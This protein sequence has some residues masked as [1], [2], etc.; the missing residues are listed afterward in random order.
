MEGDLGQGADV[1][2]IRGQAVGARLAVVY[3]GDSVVALLARSG[4]A[5]A[6]VLV[7]GSASLP[8]AV[9]VA[10]DGQLTVGAAALAASGQCPDGLVINPSL[11]LTADRVKVGEV[12]VDPVDLIAATLRAVGTA[13]DQAVVGIEITST[14]IAVPSRWGTRRRTA[15]RRAARRAG[16]SDPQI[17]DAPA[18]IVTH[19]AAA[20][21]GGSVVVCRHDG[22]HLE[23]TVLRR[24]ESGFETL[25]TSDPTVDTADPGAGP[26][27]G[28]VVAAI[29][30]TLAAADIAEGQLTAVLLDVPVAELAAVTAGLAAHLT[31]RAPV[32]VAGYAA[33]YGAL[34]MTAP[35]LAS[36]PTAADRR[37][38]ASDGARP[39]PPWIT[40][41]ARIAILGGGSL[42]LLAQV[43]A[44]T[45]RYTDRPGDPNGIFL[46]TGWSAYAL[47][48]VTA[49]FAGVAIAD[50]AADWTASR[51][52]A[53][54]RARDAAHTLG[55]SLVAA[56]AASLGLACVYAMAAGLTVEAPISMFLGWTL[57]PAFALAAPVAVAGLAL[58]PAAARDPRMFTRLRLPLTPF[59]LAVVGMLGVRTGHSNVP[60]VPSELW[61]WFER[62]GAAA[63][64]AAIAL[65][66]IRPRRW[67]AIVVPVFAAAMG[68]LISL[69]TA[70][71][72]GILL[73][74][75]IAVWWLAQSAPILW[76]VVRDLT[77][78]VLASPTVTP[79]NT[80]TSDPPS[81]N[82]DP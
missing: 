11:R 2:G 21:G 5:P 56:A 37:S 4:A 79:P 41:G 38:G 50:A 57:L 43:I 80:T 31:A 26:D 28:R 53:P 81:S 23:A 45:D 16:L 9:W 51:R 6:P 72:I 10:P 82:E 59:A 54:H 12:E 42:L 75:A 73:I 58:P 64:G 25:A 3:G 78:T 48:A 65:L 67:R 61:P 55:Y 8:A 66:L 69:D 36:A 34:A 49:L 77:S 68:A 63:I 44:G 27:P 1:T 19:H 32:V 40:H 20:L 60:Q 76:I 30:D 71:L 18:A 33:G 24:T 15:L 22:G 35:A 7:N 29:V 46:V 62:G 13:A 74:I 14:T 47:A 70:T 39:R 17:V 52:P